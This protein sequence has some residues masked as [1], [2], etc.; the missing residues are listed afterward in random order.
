[1]T[2]ILHRVIGANYPTAVG[3]QGIE[4]I[5]SLEGRWTGGPMRVGDV[6]V[7]HSLTAHKGIENRSAR[8][9]MSIDCRFQ[10]VR[11]PFNPDNEQSLPS[12]SSRPSSRTTDGIS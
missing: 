1:M 11:D 2:R 8:L 6:L 5:D 4:L 7:F 3:G 12:S 10:R 9:R